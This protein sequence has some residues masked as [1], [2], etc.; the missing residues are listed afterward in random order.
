MTKAE[1]AGEKGGRGAA[2]LGVIGE[3]VCV[4]GR[5]RGVTG[6]E[7]R[8]PG[9]VGGTRA[10]IST[11]TKS[12]VLVQAGACSKHFYFRV[13]PPLL[14]SSLAF[15]HSTRPL[16]GRGGHCPVGDIPIRAGLRGREEQGTSGAAV[17][18]RATTEASQ[19]PPPSWV[20]PTY[21]TH[22]FVL[23]SPFRHR[24]ENQSRG[25]RIGSLGSWGNSWGWRG[26]KSIRRA[27][28]R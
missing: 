24:V 13:M 23:N 3:G 27:T 17:A 12:L 25:P 26:A 6:A 14:L 1:G 5:E 9:V 19:S 7:G 8:L 22:R 4:V 16:L 28:W 2:T 20:L 18:P 15:A 10:H 21:R 11:V